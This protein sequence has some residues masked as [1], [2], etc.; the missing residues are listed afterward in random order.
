MTPNRGFTPME[1]VDDLCETN[2]PHN[3]KTSRRV[4]QYIVTK[5]H[6]WEVNTESF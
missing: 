1:L 6:L 3:R 5:N 2:K 4:T